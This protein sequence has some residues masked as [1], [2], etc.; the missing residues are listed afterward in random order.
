[1]LSHPASPV[2]IDIILIRMG[3]WN[4]SKIY[5][6]IDEMSK[7]FWCDVEFIKK[8]SSVCVIGIRWTV[9]FHGKSDIFAKQNPMLI[10]ETRRCASH[11][12]AYL[13]IAIT[14]FF[15]SSLI[16]LPLEHPPTFVAVQSQPCFLPALKCFWLENRRGKFGDVF[17]WFLW[18][19]RW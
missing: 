4:A 14:A 1:M 5:T 15:P 11:K 3:Y 8:C 17:V 2:V 12:I 6:T 19:S 7:A 9:I 18:I 13:N 16:V 10:M